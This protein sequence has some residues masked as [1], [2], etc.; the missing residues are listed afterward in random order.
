M[1]KKHTKLLLL[2]LLLLLLGLVG[3]LGPYPFKIS[4]Q[5]SIAS[6]DLAFSSE[7][8]PHD[9]KYPLRVLSKLPQSRDAKMVWDVD[10][11][12]KYNATIKIG[13]GNCSNLVF[14]F[15]SLLYRERYPFDVIHLLAP[16]GFLFGNGHTTI[17][18]P[19]EY[20]GVMQVGVYDVLE[21]GFPLNQQGQL[22]TISDVIEANF[23]ERDGLVLNPFGGGVNRSVYWSG[24]YIKNKGTLGVFKGSDVNRYFAIT[25]TIY[26]PIGS[27]QF[28]RYVYDGIALFFG[29]LPKLYISEVTY[30]RLTSA[31]V[32]WFYVHASIMILLVMRILVAALIMLV[33]YDVLNCMYV[34]LFKRKASHE[35]DSAK[36]QVGT[37]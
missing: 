31:R 24:G 5:L 12:G 29:Y 22:A 3:L 32:N 1:L 2:L 9:P 17:A 36:S 4:N 21:T 13:S 25:D 33:I 8:A 26:W 18:M 20:K 27:K 10:T 6:Q 35:A 28:E 7:N 30:S 34:R 37:D 16:E 11:A 14:G 19:Y 15:A 23:P